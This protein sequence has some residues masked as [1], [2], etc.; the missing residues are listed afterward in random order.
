MVKQ[1]LTAEAKA[2]ETPE[3]P[4]P[5]RSTCGLIRPI[6]DMGGDYTF[7]HWRE[8]HDVMT[9]ALD[10]INYDL[11]LVSETESVGVVLNEI[12]SNLYSDEIVIADVSNK[13]ANVMFELGMRMAFQKPVIIV[14]DLDTDLSFDIQAV[15][16]LRYPRSLRYGD[17]LAFQTDLRGAVLATVAAYEKGEHR[18]Y[19]SQFG[20]VQV[21]G[22]GSNNVDASQIAQ[23]VQEIKR[24]VQGLLSSNRP[25][26]RPGTRRSITSAGIVSSSR[27]TKVIAQYTRAVDERMADELSAIPQVRRVFISELGLEITIGGD[28]EMEREQGRNQVRAKVAAQG[29]HLLG[30]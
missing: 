1:A 19:L 13:N 25:D 24:T 27:M 30:E 18:D 4:L 20:P 26:V 7:K 22:L 2:G 17:A 12:V 16:H 29:G 10:E 3:R 5:K 11:R 8:V 9:E 23:D 15:K 28:S 14:T 21:T 6:A